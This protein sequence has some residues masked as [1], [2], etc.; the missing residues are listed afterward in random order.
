MLLPDLASLDD[1]SELAGRIRLAIAQPVVL[2]GLVVDFGASIGVSVFPVDSSDAQELLRH[3][4]VAMYVAK[5]GGLGVNI[6]DP[7]RDCHDPIAL[8]LV[9]DL[10]NGMVNDELVLHYAPQLTVGGPYAADSVG[11]PYAADS[12]GGPY[13]AETAEVFG[14]QVQVCW[15]SPVRGHLP[16]E[17]FVPLLESGELLGQLADL[18]IQM[19]IEQAGVWFDAGRRLPVCVAVPTRV[20][21]DQTLPARVVALLNQHGVPPELLT[22]ALM[23][24]SLGPPVGAVV[25]AMR[26]IK[27]LGVRICLTEFGSGTS[28]L[29]MLRDLPV[30]ALTID[31]DFIETLRSDHRSR[32]L[33]RAIIELANQLELTAIAAGVPDARTSEILIRL[34]CHVIQGPQVGPALAID[35]FE[36][37]LVRSWRAPDSRV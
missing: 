2:N 34:G 6:Y 17:A 7:D 35:D 14:V 15:Q 36:K 26:R 22:I 16:A 21:L 19:A 18:T 37:W 20:L 11:G 8:S 27:D 32:V 23:E 25:S 33:V 30:D 10:R 12:V 5:R 9:G 4:D 31:R 29:A 3:A 1:L 24:N 28:S 13:A